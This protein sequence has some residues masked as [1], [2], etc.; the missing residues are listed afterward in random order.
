MEVLGSERRYT[1]ISLKTQYRKMLHFGLIQSAAF[2]FDF[3][4]D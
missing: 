4:K 1:E 2:F 3:F